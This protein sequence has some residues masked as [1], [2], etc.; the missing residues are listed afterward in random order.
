MTTN[1]IRTLTLSA[2]ALTMGSAAYAQDH[3]VAQVPFSF[4]IN[5]TEMPAGNYSID[6]PSIGTRSVVQVN[7]GH[8]N[9]M[10]M[11]IV[12]NGNEPGAARLIFTCGETS[13]CRLAEVWDGSGAQVKLPKPK[14]TSAEKERLAVVIVRKSEAD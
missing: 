1:W 11:G 3:L 6:R 13:G 10:A 12:V 14:L 5:G 2:A 9:K 8:N 4:W 7:D